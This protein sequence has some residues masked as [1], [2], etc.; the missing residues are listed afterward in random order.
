MR[1]KL[2]RE[3]SA[4]LQESEFKVD[5]AQMV[6]EDDE[7]EESCLQIKVKMD[8]TDSFAGHPCSTCIAHSCSGIVS[9]SIKFKFTPKAIR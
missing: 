3:V 4:I 9:F 2:P 1:V 6:R 8:E 5:A 7:D